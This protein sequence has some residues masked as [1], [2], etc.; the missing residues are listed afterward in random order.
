[1]GNWFVSIHFHSCLFSTQLVINTHGEPRN[2]EHQLMILSRIS[3]TLIF[4]FLYYGNIGIQKI[5]CQKH[6]TSARWKSLSPDSSACQFF[7]VIHR[8]QYFLPE[9]GHGNWKIFHAKPAIK[10]RKFIPFLF[11]LRQALSVAQAGLEWVLRLL[12]SHHT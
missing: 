9:G 7:K 10:V 1:M 2:R 5:D 12:T 11:L 3:A 6:V 8:I 4:T